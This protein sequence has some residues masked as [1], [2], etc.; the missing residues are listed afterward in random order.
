MDT[1][2]RRQ[3]LHQVVFSTPLR[4]KGSWREG[5]GRQRKHPSVDA[6][7]LLADKRVCSCHS[8]GYSNPLC[9]LAHY[10][11]ILQ[12]LCVPGILAWMLDTGCQPACCR[13]F[14]S[15]LKQLKHHALF[16]FTTGGKQ[17]ALLILVLIRFLGECIQ[18]SVKLR[19]HG[20][21][22]STSAKTHATDFPT[23]PMGTNNAVCEDQHLLL[24]GVS[25]KPRRL[26][27]RAVSPFWCLDCNPNSSDSPHLQHLLESSLLYKESHTPLSPLH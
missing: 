11:L 25:V 16:R 15:F 8:G 9:F 13:V 3:F 17:L 7:E 10:R 4:K 23:L 5:I 21:F 6:D 18:N 19:T 1:N 24:Q 20:I 14:L 22:R 27:L 12:F 2:K 26:S